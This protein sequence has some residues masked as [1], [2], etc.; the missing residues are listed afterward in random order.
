MFDTVIV[1]AS[2][3]ITAAPAVGNP[4]M[5][6]NTAE[7]TGGS[8]IDGGAD[9]Y[10]VDSDLEDVGGNGAN[11]VDDD[12]A[13]NSTGGTDTPGDQDDF[14]FAEIVIVVCDDVLT[15]A[16][17]Q[18]ICGGDDPVAFTITV[19]AF[20]GSPSVIYQWQLSTTSATMG[21][22][23]LTDETTDSYDSP[24]ITETSYF[25]LIAMY[26]CPGTCACTD[27]SNVVTLTHFVEPT[28]TVANP[29]T[30][31]STQSIDLTN[32]ASIL[33]TDLGGT[34]SSS[35][36]GTF[37]TSTDFATATTY[38][39]GSTDITA[40]QVTLTLTS[41]DPDGPCLAVPD[42]VTFTILKVDCGTFPWNG[43]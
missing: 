1:Q 38:T 18:D 22:A 8:L 35:G 43:N 33:P 10:D 31:C 30:I 5:I 7:I 2:F 25:R 16:G 32:G 26:N 27:T 17:D 3:T 21:F 15:I 14:D 34:W 37:A 39:P 4:V 41:N 6:R 28:V 29:T 9:T 20:P 42:S 36:N 19:P 40:G 23:D 24:A 13:D 12:V 11:E